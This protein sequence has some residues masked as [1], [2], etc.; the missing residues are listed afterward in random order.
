MASFVENTTILIAAVRTQR[1]SKF[2][3]RTK[4]RSTLDY[5]EIKRVFADHIHADEDITHVSMCY[6][7]EPR[8]EE[9]NQINQTHQSYLS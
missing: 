2:T 9:I 3:R 5:D 6:H 4:R 7:D 1:R 8:L